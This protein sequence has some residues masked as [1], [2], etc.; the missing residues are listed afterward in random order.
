[1][2]VMDHDQVETGHSG[3]I[4]SV[5]Y[6]PDGTHIA[7]GSGGK[8]VRIFDPQMDIDGATGDMVRVVETGHSQAITS[9]TYAPDS[10]HIATGSEDRM[11]LQ[12]G[13][14]RSRHE[15][16]QCSLDL[17]CFATG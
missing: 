6:T 1:M 14:S 2:G 16:S 17:S 8:T 11:A 7:T 5:A 13:F 3:W 15:F 10:T 12:F 9:V 4:M